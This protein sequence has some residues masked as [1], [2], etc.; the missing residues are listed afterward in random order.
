[1]TKVRVTAQVEGFVKSLAP[2]P[3]K[4]LRTGIKSLAAGQGDIKHLEGDLVGWSRL[5]VHTY[6][7]VFK[8]IWT[9]GQRIVDCVY[10]NRR[11]VVYDL[12]KEILRNQFLKD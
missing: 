11:S 10:A 8:E 4:A 5:R 1:M 2:D 3:R 7:V 12:F 6:R 9:D